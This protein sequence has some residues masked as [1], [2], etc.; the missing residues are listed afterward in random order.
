MLIGNGLTLGKVYSFNRESFLV[1]TSKGVY[2]TIEDGFWII[3]Q[4]DK[5]K[6]M[7]NEKFNRLYMLK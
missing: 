5:V 3:V 6:I 2:E 7:T 4:T 1:R